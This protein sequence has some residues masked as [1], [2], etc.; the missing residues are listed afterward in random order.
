MFKERG[1]SVMVKYNLGI[2]LKY[3]QN[4]TIKI[5]NEKFGKLTNFQRVCR[6]IRISLVEKLK[7]GLF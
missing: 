2:L 3:Y 1:I 5:P 4:L 7:E 6:F